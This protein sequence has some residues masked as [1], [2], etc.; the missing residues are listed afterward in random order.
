VESHRGCLRKRASE[1]TE[2]AEGALRCVL[3]EEADRG[4]NPRVG[5]VRSEGGCSHELALG[6]E[7]PA[8]PLERGPE[9]KLLADTAGARTGGEERELPWRGELRQRRRRREISR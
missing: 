5:I 7:R 2:P 4:R 6:R 9:Q 1:R 8:E 3:V